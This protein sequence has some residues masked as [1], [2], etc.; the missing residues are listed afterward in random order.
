MRA[1]KIGLT[2]H[3]TAKSYIRTGL[4]QL[5]GRKIM[6]ELR[7]LVVLLLLAA[8]IACLFFPL[9]YSGPMEPT[10]IVVSATGNTGIVT[11]MEKNF[12][13]KSAGTLTTSVT[14]PELTVVYQAPSTSTSIGGISAVQVAASA[15]SGLVLITL[16]VLL[17]RRRG[18]K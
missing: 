12:L 9:V 8:S 16:A 13:N 11:I 7:P 1:E 3:T 10:P 2:T 4:E 5:L 15:L 18:K 14:L 17:I 6:V